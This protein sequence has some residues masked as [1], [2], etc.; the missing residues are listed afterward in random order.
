MVHA[1]EGPRPQVQRV[2]EQLLLGGGQLLLAGSAAIIWQ[3][4]THAL[5][6][7]GES[8]YPDI[9]A[10]VQTFNAIMIAG[11]GFFSARLVIK[12]YPA[13][14]GSGR[15]IWLPPAA[16]LILFVGWNAFDG[17]DWRLISDHYFWEYPGQKLAPIERD[18][19]TYPVLSATAYSLG[20]L[21]HA[22]QRRTPR[23]GWSNIGL[24]LQESAGLA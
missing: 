16:L 23:E 22:V 9:P 15:W 24:P 14:A 21:T 4:C 5:G 11:L 13:A 17:W 6:W 10:I 18:I 1:T 7:D 2:T 20:V 3:F 19:L 8:Y 12:L